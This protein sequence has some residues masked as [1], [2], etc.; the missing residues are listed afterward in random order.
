MNMSLE[1]DCKVKLFE[2]QN[3]RLLPR[4][5]SRFDSKEGLNNANY[6]AAATCGND[7]DIIDSKYGNLDHN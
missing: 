3:A 2:V 7:R 6:I 4:L 1:R 5:K